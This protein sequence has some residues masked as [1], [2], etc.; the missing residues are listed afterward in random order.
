[1]NGA[2]R[3]SQVHIEL[4][5]G[6]GGRRALHGASAFS[7]ATTFDLSAAAHAVALPQPEPRIRGVHLVML[8]VCGLAVGQA[9]PPG[10]RQSQDPLQPL[11]LEN[12]L[13]RVH[14]R[15]LM[16]TRPILIVFISP[17]HGRIFSAFWPP[18]PTGW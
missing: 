10:V 4:L 3:S 6:A 17:R 5:G 15:Y 9:G 2:G 1:M 8:P 7:S 13:L 14:H 12:G 18:D 11:N 16:Q